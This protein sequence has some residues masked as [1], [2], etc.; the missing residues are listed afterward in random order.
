MIRNHKALVATVVAFGLVA[1][2]CGDD[3]DSA[4]DDAATD[5]AATDDAATDDAATDDAA[6]D[7]AGALPGT[8]VSI[9]MA[10]A[11]W[12]TEDPNAYVARAVLQEL[13]YEV[14]D[15]KE[16]EL[17][18]SNAYIAMAQGDADFWINSWYPGHNSW[19]ENELPDGSK[20]GDHLTVVGEMMMAGGLQG[21]LMT[22]SFA[23]EFGISS[24]DELNSNPDALAAYDASDPVPGNGVADI[25]G[26]QESWTCDDIITSQ[27]A[28][29]G[30]ENI[31]QTIA[32]YDAMFAE[33]VTKADAGEPMLIYTWTPSAYITQLRPGDNVVWATVN[34]VVD[35]SNPTG[36]EG[37]EEHDQRPGIAG[38]GPEECPGSTG[39]DCQLGWVAA[40]I[41]ATANSEFLDANPAVRQFLE[42]FQMSVLQV[43]LMN[44]EMGD[45]TDV[46]QLAATW[47]EDNR[48]TVDGW[49]ASAVAA[50]G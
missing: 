42:D 45:G 47:I 7:D 28:F 3:D 12:S 44:V 6:T 31:E 39:T 34:E 36:V 20:V 25:Y 1:A 21:Y 16:L 49:I 2:A 30:W 10:K 33:A 8:G 5:D 18:P 32:G 22:K 50:A 29:S 15:P 24:I 14:T 46:E 27:I 48:A 41:Q 9:T 17:G 43:S 4:T 23:E 11:D 37:G 38:I 26:C 35:D 13:G 40:D 19:L